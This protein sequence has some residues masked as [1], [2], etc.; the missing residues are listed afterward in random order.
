MSRN[1][2][3]RT[4]RQPRIG[5]EADEKIEKA[6]KGKETYYL[7]T[8]LGIV[9]EYSDKDTKD[10]L[11]KLAIS[12]IAKKE[13]GLIYFDRGIFCGCKFYSFEKD[14]QNGKIDI[15][16]CK[17]YKQTKTDSLKFKDIKKLIT[18]SK[19]ENDF[20]YFDMY[21]N[22]LEQKQMQFRIPKSN[23]LS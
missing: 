13:G 20:G 11:N 2:D 14:F 23:M 10:K 6:I 7:P 15:T 16:K 8:E 18:T 22:H 3:R 1:I 19:D 17:G 12:E 9:Y 4:E 5:P 21:S